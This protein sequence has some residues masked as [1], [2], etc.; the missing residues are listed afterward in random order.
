VPTTLGLTFKDFLAGFGTFAAGKIA[1]SFLLNR[2]LLNCRF[3]KTTEL[4]V[5]TIHP[6]TFSVAR[7]V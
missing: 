6:I 7:Y 5:R 1:L 3:N 2:A 4:I